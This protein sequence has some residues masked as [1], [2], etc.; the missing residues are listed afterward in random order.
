MSEEKLKKLAEKYKIDIKELTKEWLEQEKYYADQGVEGDLKQLAYNYLLNKYR[1]KN[2]K[3]TGITMFEG[4]KIGD[5]GLRD[6][7]RIYKSQVIKMKRERG[8]DA[9]AMEGYY[10]LID[11]EY[12]LTDNRDFD[13]FGNINKHKGELLDPEKREYSRNIW[14]I[15]RPIN[16]MKPFKLMMLSTSD[17]G[18]SLAWGSVPFFRLAK[19]PAIVKSDKPYY[20]ARATLRKQFYKGYF[21]ALNDDKF[22]YYKVFTEAMR[23][24]T[25][26][27]DEVE[28]YY[29]ATKDK[30]NRLIVVRGLLSSI[31]RNKSF[32]YGEPEA[33]TYIHISDFN[34]DRKVLM[35]L[36]PD[37]VGLTCGV[38]SDIFVI[39]KPVVSQY[40]DRE[41]GEI[42]SREI[43]INAYGIFPV[44]GLSV[45]RELYKEEEEE[46]V[47]WKE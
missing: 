32:W 46:A 23:R 35:V 22:D 29:N 18:L 16:S 15:A 43:R 8:I 19:F 11:G 7:I 36:V 10:K 14:L 6:N 31:N 33:A 4:F 38:A 30:W 40:K 9:L 26:K 44:P 28:E 12:Y 41:T 20:N 1:R 39:G 5:M 17:N 42:L 13:R 25:R 21:R 34:D 2:Q 3:I 45:P 27:I 47:G 37:F 24:W